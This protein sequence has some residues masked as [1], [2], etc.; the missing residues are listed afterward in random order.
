ML[1]VAMKDGNIKEYGL[2]EFTEYE[3]RREVFVVIKGAQWI[4]M[5]NWDSVKEVHFT[6]SQL[7]VVNATIIMIETRAAIGI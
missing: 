1:T 2:G 5:F 3:W 7:N 6:E 4:G